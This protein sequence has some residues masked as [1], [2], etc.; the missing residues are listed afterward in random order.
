MEQG[1]KKRLNKL[2]L[3][4]LKERIMNHNGENSSQESD[5]EKPIELKHRVTD[6]TFR[7]CTQREQ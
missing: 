4:Y 7:T 3:E 1:I 5:L 6:P 2:R